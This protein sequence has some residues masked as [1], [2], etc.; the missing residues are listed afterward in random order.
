MHRRRYEKL[1]QYVHVSIAADEA[2]TVKL[3]KVRP[4]IDLCQLNFAAVYSSIRK[5]VDGAV[6]E[7]DGHIG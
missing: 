5:A 1:S 2:R 7:S 6:S 4:F 3:T